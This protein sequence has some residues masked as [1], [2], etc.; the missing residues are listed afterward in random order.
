MQQQQK[1]H[2]SFIFSVQVSTISDIHL[3]GSS[4]LSIQ[5]FFITQIF[6]SQSPDLLCILDIKI[7]YHLLHLLHKKLFKSNPTIINL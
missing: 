3:L 1:Q 4:I 7:R 5:I 2:D 6:N